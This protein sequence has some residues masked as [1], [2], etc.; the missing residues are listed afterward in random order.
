MFVTCFKLFSKTSS[1]RLGGL[2]A[3]RVFIV[4]LQ[5]PEHK[6][7]AGEAAGDKHSCTEW[8]SLIRRLEVVSVCWCGSSNKQTNNNNWKLLIRVKAAVWYWVKAERRGS[9]GLGGGVRKMGRMGW[10][11]LIPI[12][13]GIDRAGSSY[14]AAALHEASEDPDFRIIKTQINPHR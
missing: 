10:G 1:L 2:K 4:C 9:L 12:R 13:S 3:E 14:L 11:G 7:Q 8:Q 5:R 6:A